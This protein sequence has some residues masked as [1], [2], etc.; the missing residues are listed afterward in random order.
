MSLLFVLANSSAFAELKEV[1]KI[2]VCGQTLNAEVARSDEDRSRGLMGR[3][4]LNKNAAMIFV[5]ESEEPLSFWMKNVPFDI[6]IGF[7]DAKGKYVSHH[8]MKGTSPLQREATLP[9]YKSKAPAKYA[10]EVRPN[11]FKKHLSSNCKLSP[12]L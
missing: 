4:S 9:S 8:L 7:F 10:V 6:D 5:F 2:Q 3:T 12:L 1:V 11:F